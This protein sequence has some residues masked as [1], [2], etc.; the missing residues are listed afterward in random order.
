MRRR[1]LS[2]RIVSVV[3]SMLAAAVWAGV[4]QAAHAFT[5]IASGDLIVSL[6]NLGTVQEYT[7]S[8][9]LVQ[10][11]MNI[12]VSIPT[13]SAFDGQGNLYVSEFGANAIE[14]IDHVT[15]AA[16]VFSDNTILADG[17]SYNSPESVAFNAGFTKL[18]V[19]DANRFGR[20]GGIHVVDASTGKGLDFLPISSSSGSDGRGESDWLAFNAANKLY[21]TNENRVQGVMQVDLTTK[22]IVSPSF[23]PNLPN[24]GYAI[25]F[26]KLGDVWIGDT[27]TVLEY[28]S[29]G[30]LLKTITNGS[31]SVVFAAV[32]DPAG[33]TFYGGDAVNGNVY[34]YDLNGN[35]LGTFNAGSG[36]SGLSVAGASLPNQPPSVTT[37]L[38][39]GGQS[40]PVITVPSGTVVTDSA[41]LTGANA[42]NA[43]GTVTYTVYAEPTCTINGVSAGTKPVTAG[44][45]PNSDPL[46]LNGPTGTVF[47]WQAVYSG[48]ATTGNNPST[49]VCGTETVTVIT[50]EQPITATGTSVSA[51]EGALFTGTVA[52]FTDPTTT[53]TAAEYT[54]SINWGDGHTSTGIVSGPI[55]GLFTVTGSNTYAEEGPYTVTVT[56]TDIDNAA[57]GAT[58]ASTATVSDAALL[59]S[60]AVVATSSQ[61]F[62]GLTATFTDAASPFGTL[63]DFTAMINWGDGTTSAG[64]VTGPDG[65][66]YSVSG[67][68]T[69]ASTGPFTIT[70]TIS[71]VGG[72]AASTSGCTG[73]VFAF[74]PGGGAFV[75]G[76]N[77]SANGK[78]V[79]FWGA[80]WWKLNSLSGGSAPA[81]FKGF[82]E[83]PTTPACAVGWSTDTGNSTPPPAG[84]LPAFMGVIVTS[85][86]MQSGSIDSGNTVHIVI[87]QTNPGYQPNP[88]NAGTG[89]VV[90]QVC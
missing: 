13:G 5:P 79:T 48:D 9:T 11:L 55:G 70:T 1:W 38:S 63:S 43:G 17:T 6:G 61:S 89:T 51:T 52:T 31:F 82:A 83:A 57:N 44:V 36:V 59:A 24:V 18:Y 27:N 53:A 12:P 25:S 2:N 87:V 30:A 32:F 3:V 41:T 33:D 14:R 67:T 71:D 37:S 40:G 29:T 62:S 42:A 28:S 66:P 78:K 84:P 35:L 90:A 19:S 69:Y 16:T 4:P 8:G 60:C 74:A 22:D 34:T 20:D 68:H 54:A 39:G 65:G 88:G 46:T 45:V 58:T 77:N 26:D 76:D 21:M 7:P 72:S 47:Y 75:I 56:I 15:G 10:T 80:Q 85:S 64:T 81:S 49:S 50:T 73:L 23:V 86:A